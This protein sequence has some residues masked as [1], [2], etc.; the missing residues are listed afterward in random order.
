MTHD[1]AEVELK[2]QTAAGTT[3]VSFNVNYSFQ[4]PA[5]DESAA[6]QDGSDAAPPPSPEFTVVIERN[7]HKLGFECQVAPPGSIL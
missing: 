7:G 1:R 3:T 2:A 5:D 6:A 4:P